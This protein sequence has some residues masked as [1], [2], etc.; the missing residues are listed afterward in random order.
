MTTLTT[1]LETIGVLVSGLL[2]RAAVA[3][4]FALALAL[5]ILLLT[6]AWE[7]VKARRERR[8]EPEWAGA[9]RFRP[10]A[11]YAPGHAWLAASWRG[12][13]VGLD[14]LARRIV[15]VPEAVTLPAPGARLRAGEPAVILR[16]G[17]R[18]AVLPAPVAGTVTAANDALLQLPALLA[19]EPYGRGWLYRIRPAGGRPPS[20]PTGEQA[21]AWLRAE[22]ARFERALERELGYAAADGGHPPPHAE[23]A[24]DDGQWRRIAEEFLG[25]AA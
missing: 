7:L 14:D 18:V 12:L 6:K 21:R 10:D 23:A 5:P 2:I 22:S 20:L 8:P 17:P 1:A 13:R 4:V 16:R 11:L 25:T 24:L 3:L 9:L 15:G 19:R